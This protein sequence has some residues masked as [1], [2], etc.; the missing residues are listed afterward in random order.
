MLPIS[1][2][3]LAQTAIFFWIVAGSVSLARGFATAFKPGQSQDFT[4]V[5][6][7]LGKWLFYG[8]N[9]YYLAEIPA[10]YPPHAIAFLSPLSIPLPD[11]G[12]ALWSVLN[13]LL[14][15]LTAFLAVRCFLPAAPRQAA[16]VPCVLFL[17][18][19]G[20][21]IG[22][23]NGQFSLLM[24]TFGLLAVLAAEKR[25]F[26]SGG[27]I[28]L[29]MMKPHVGAAF[30]L[31]SVFT[32][33]FR[34]ATASVGVTV[35]GLLLFSLRIGRSPIAVTF[36]FFGVLY[37]QFGDKTFLPGALELRPLLHA[38]IP[39]YTGAEAAHL[40]ILLGLLG[41][42]CVIAWREGSLTPKQRDLF[43]LQLSS[44]WVL[45]AVFHNSY[46]SILMLP[47]MVALSISG[48]FRSSATKRS[49]DTLALWI[50]QA[51]LVLEIPGLWWK[52]GKRYDLSAYGSFGQLIGHLDRLMVIFFFFYLV[53][54]VQ[55]YGSAQQLPPA[56]RSGVEQEADPNR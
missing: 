3:R 38:V 42:I 7:W 11:W 50:L 19:A 9:P 54:R 20:V 12:I 52:L 24:L 53:K 45:M 34:V 30:F 26:L 29:S 46:D 55:S 25:P 36:D 16:L 49:F 47:V 23:G 8:A 33:R 40:L 37:R 13:L 6:V 4:N 22:L 51:A 43:L 35:L 41:I 56:T 1:K 39:D 32:N 21:R 17:S 14:P 2:N 28:A 44:L 18:W 31:W 10:N 48:S 27:F 15:P 5:V